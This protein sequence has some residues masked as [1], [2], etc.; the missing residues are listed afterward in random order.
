MLLKNTFG[1][2]ILELEK[3]GLFFLGGSL[4]IDLPQ[5]DKCPNGEFDQ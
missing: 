1:I 3:F 2:K 4:A 5:C